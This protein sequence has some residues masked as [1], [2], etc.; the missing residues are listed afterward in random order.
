MAVATGAVLLLTGLAPT[1]G[2][3]LTGLLTR[4]PLYAVTLAAFAHHQQGSGAAVRVLRGLL[5]GLFGFAGF[6]VVLT[7]LI[8]RAGLIPA[9]VAALAV[10]LAGQSVSLWVL[11]R[12]TAARESAG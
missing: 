6:F 11:R 1:L 3:R 4:F 9:F 5:L 7:T 8:A 2:P 10:A 12:G